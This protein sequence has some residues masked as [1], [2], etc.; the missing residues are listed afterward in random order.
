ME[1]IF[2]AA[3]AVAFVVAMSFA[4]NSPAMRGTAMG[5][6]FLIGSTAIIGPI[7]FVI[8][9]VILAVILFTR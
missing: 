9:G 4:P 6:A 2:L 5:M 3:L 8:A 7:G 1:I